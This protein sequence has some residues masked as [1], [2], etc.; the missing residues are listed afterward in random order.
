MQPVVRLHPSFPIEIAPLGCAFGIRSHCRYTPLRLQCDLILP[1]TGPAW[2]NAYQSRTPRRCDR[3]EHPPISIG[4]EPEGITPR[5]N[6]KPG[7]ALRGVPA[8]KE[9]YSGTN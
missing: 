1:Q 7:A 2:S 9:T 5:A 6:V 4:I 3:P 8:A